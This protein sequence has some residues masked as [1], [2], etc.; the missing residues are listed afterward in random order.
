[1]LTAINQLNGTYPFVSVCN[2]FLTKI[3]YSKSNLI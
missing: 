3:E 1:M 2:I